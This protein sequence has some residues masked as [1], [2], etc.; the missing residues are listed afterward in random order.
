[1]PQVE[2]NALVG[3]EQLASDV[4]ET[5]E[6]L[7]PARQGALALHEPEFSER[8]EAMVLECIRSTFV[9]SVG[10]FV[11]EFEVRLAEHCGVAHAVAM[12]NGTAALE[13]ALRVAGVGPNTEVLLPSLTFVATP[14][15]VSHLNAVPH[16]VDINEQ[17]LGIDPAALRQHL[18]QVGESKAGRLFNRE[19]GRPIS[20]IVPVHVFGHPVA[21]DELVEVAD[22]FGIAV[23]EDAAEALGSQ[24]RGRHCAAMGLLG[25]ISF[26]GNKI[27]TTGGGGAVLTNDADL[28]DTA[29]HLSTT[30]G[31]PDLRIMQEPEHSVSNYWLNTLLL[32]PHAASARDVILQSL[33]DAGFMARPVWEPMHTLSMYAEAPRALLPNTESI[34]ER[35]INLPSS[36]KLVELLQ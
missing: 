34:A 16:F 33:N 29:R 9:S 20:A 15:A 4:L 21:M 2:H 22:A 32:E 30:A 14:N 13:V 24:Y 27:I 6:G 26:N 7:F 28:A 1:M 31:H 36:A 25:A 19:T 11:S 23:V 8:A 5:L 3:A 17:T 10:A 12:V 18:N 35:I